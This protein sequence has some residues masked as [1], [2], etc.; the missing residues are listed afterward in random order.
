MN[1]TTL[2]KVAI[3]IV[4]NIKED[5]YSLLDHNIKILETKD[6]K[7]ISK[8]AKKFDNDS[9]YTVTFTRV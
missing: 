9:K 2:N 7:E 3:E 1:K 4:Y 5:S 6:S 8:I